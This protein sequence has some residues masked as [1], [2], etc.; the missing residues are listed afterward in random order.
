MPGNLALIFEAEGVDAGVIR[1]SG[2]C[3]VAVQHGERSFCQRALEPDGLAGKPVRHVPEVSDETGFAV[4]T[5][6]SC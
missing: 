2:P 3:P 5:W 1:E 6:G 4:A